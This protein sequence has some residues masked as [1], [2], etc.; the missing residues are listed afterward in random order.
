M[1]NNQKY[2]LQLCIIRMI[3][4]A[5]SAFAINARFQ[6]MLVIVQLICIYLVTII[7]IKCF[8]SLDV[9]KIIPFNSNATIEK[10]RELVCVV[11]SRALV[12]GYL[13]VL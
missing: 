2:Q 10:A 9:A 5:I 6:L 7:S 11:N 3:A 12:I 13:R 4:G 1:F 8:R